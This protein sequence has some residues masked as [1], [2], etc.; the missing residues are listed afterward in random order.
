LKVGNNE[1]RN[2]EGREGPRM[3]RNEEGISEEEDEFGVMSNGR[4]YM[5]LKTRAKK[6][7]LRNEFERREPCAIV[8][9]VE[10][11]HI[12]GEEEDS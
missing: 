10:I 12:K 4:R 6:G 2:E 8:Q 1:G 3:Q 7:D 9:I 5:R 11:L